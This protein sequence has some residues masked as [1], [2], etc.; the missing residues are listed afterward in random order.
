MKRCVICGLEATHTV[1]D[2]NDYYCEECAQDNF[3]D[4]AYLQKIE[5]GAMKLKEIVDKKMEEDENEL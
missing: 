3:G 5:E 2:T 4:I 1:K